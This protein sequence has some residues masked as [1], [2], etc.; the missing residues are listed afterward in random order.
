MGIAVLGPL[1]V[2]GHTDALSPRD[3]VVLSALVVRAR[4]PLSTESLADALWG[5]APPSSWSKVVYG[6]VWRLRK[7][8]GGP[9]IDKGPSG[10]RLTLG[11]DELDHRLFER[12]L[13]RGRDAL[14]GDDPGRATYLLEEGLD[15]WRGRALSDLEDWEPGRVEA[16]RLTGLR[17]DA[18]ELRIEA[19]LRTGHAAAVLEQART[20]VAQAPYRERR[21]ALLATAFYQSGRQR[22]ALGAL[23]RARTLLVEELGLDPGPELVGLEQA[24]LRQDPSLAPD[25]PGGASPVCPYRGLLPYDAADADLFFGREDDVVACLRRVRDSNILV[26]VGPSGVGKSSLVCAGVVAALTSADTPVLVTSPG[27]HPLASLVGLKPRGRQ[28]LVVDQAEEAVTLCADAAERERY[29]TALATHV[30][31]GGGLVL[32][33]RAD[34]LGDLAPYADVVRILEVGLYLLAPMREADL[35][36]AIE[37]PAHRAGLRLEPG[38]VDLMVREVDGE[39]AGL[40]LLSHVL[41]ET[42]ERRE[43]TTLTVEAYKAT[44]GIQHAVSQSAE[45][46]YDAM[47]ETQRIRLRSLLL[48]LVMPTDGEPVRARVA[49]DKVADDE[50]HRLL[51]EQL[52]EAR[53]L[54]IDGETV[55]IAHEALVRVWPRLRDW[56]DDDIDG[57]RLFRHLVV[58]AEAWDEMGR[59]DSELYRGRRLARTLTWRERSSPELSQTE[60]AFLAAS[61]AR[62]ASELRAAQERFRRERRANYRLHGAL[63]GVAGLAVL[64]LVAGA[65]AMRNAEDAGDQR[66][67]AQRAALRAE[68]GRASAQALD[69]PV[70]ATSLLVQVAAL[71][72]D[73]SS[74]QVWENLA[75]TLTRTGPLR[76]FRQA[77]GSDGSD[78]AVAVAT[79]ADGTL[80]ATSNPNGGVQLYD[81]RTLETVPFG[82]DTPSSVVRFSPDGRFLAAAVNQWTEPGRTRIAD[83]PIRLYDLPEGRLSDRQLGGWPSGASVEYAMDFSA[84]GR[85]VAAGVNRWSEEAATWRNT[86]AAM[87]WDLGDPEV[88][89]LEVPVP[90]LAL[91]ALSPD[92]RR[93]FT[94]APGERPIRA[95]DV[96]SG[97]LLGTA[98]SAAVRVRSASDLEVSPDGSTLAVAAGS[99]VRLLDTDTLADTATPLQGY[100]RGAVEYSPDGSTLLTSSQRDAVVWDTRSGAQLRRLVGHSDAVSDAAIAPDGR[101]VYTATFFGGELMAWDL[102]ATNALTTRGASTAPAPQGLDVALPSPGGET[103]AR[104]AG[105]RLWFVDSRTG[106]AT[107]PGRT[108]RIVWRQDWSPDSRWFLTIGPGVLTL[109]D[110]TT[111]RRVAERSYEDGYGVITAFTADSLQVH[112]HDRRGT[113]ETLDLPSLRRSA[114][115][116]EVGDVKAMAADPRDGSVLALGRDAS[117]TRFDPVTGRV[118]ASGPAGLV[119]DEYDDGEPLGSM[120][121]PDGSRL[122]AHHPDGGVRLLDTETLEW[123]STGTAAVSADGN[124]AF[125]HDGSQFASL[126][127]EGVRLWDGRTGE[128]QA[129]IPLPGGTTDAAVA[130]LGDGSGLLVTSP[131]GRTWTLDTRPASWLERACALAGRDLTRDEWERYFPE[132]DYRVTCPQRS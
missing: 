75:A 117:M 130:Y 90:D 34:H 59:P 101:T 94:A 20:L 120:L 27:V 51:V 71:G 119:A 83:L 52:V 6:C 66:N 19:E 127:A 112:V 89:V 77:T 88:P 96:S 70:L 57:Q 126:A 11:D 99:S 44:G 109:W 7:V 67:L 47:D 87:V 62:S 18:E 110:P 128:Y 50:P 9:A 53:L 82:D 26:V 105:R 45:T 33:L 102:R 39:P 46:L 104:R 97:R 123:A 111:G 114:G 13:E 103:V 80:V 113:L 63:A 24:L 64:A 31:A 8:L 54:S 41:R 122:A 100:T 116:V 23:Q 76:Q 48:R 22:D 10:Y 92:G 108:D 5:N 32:A 60:T 68:A 85:R 131:D 115:P 129:S 16:A 125:A 73:D 84:D 4:E 86:G 30:G 37:G 17:M 49:R 95:Y 98:R 132:R 118:L 2:D 42:W 91:V 3:R 61:S 28:T 74:A 81:A 38:L 55:Q 21:W 1:R 106:A 69:E 56:L 65:L 78:M 72:L 14:A 29:F 35:R 93:L 40:P 43:G 36:R 12:L 121:S 15:L 124:I 58:A 107:D 25:T 79:N